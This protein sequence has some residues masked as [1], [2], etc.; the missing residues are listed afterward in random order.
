MQVLTIYEPKLLGHKSEEAYE[1]K[2]FGRTNTVILKSKAW[3]QNTCIYAKVAL[4][5]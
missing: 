1:T 4:C 5:F 2:R 3:H